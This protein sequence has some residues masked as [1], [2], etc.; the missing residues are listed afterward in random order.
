MQMLCLGRLSYRVTTRKE[1]Y[2]RGPSIM[3]RPKELSLLS[4]QDILSYG[5]G[6]LLSKQHG[7]LLTISSQAGQF[8]FIPNRNPN[9]YTLALGPALCWDSCQL[10]RLVLREWLLSQEVGQH[11]G[12][13]LGRVQMAA[14]THLT[15][16]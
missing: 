4:G 14:A 3:Q 6:F 1:P 11:A 8:R 13:T 9:L 5:S 15:T 2:L 12:Q 7:S 10:Y 16:K